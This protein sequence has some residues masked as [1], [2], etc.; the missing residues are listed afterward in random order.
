M[1]TLQRNLMATVLGLATLGL[2]AAA[3]AQADHDDVRFKLIL[4]TGDFGAWYGHGDGYWG[5]HYRRPKVVHNYYYRDDH[6]HGRHHH[7]P[8]KRVVEKYYYYFDGHPGKHKGHK[9]YKQDHGHHKGH[10]SRFDYRGDRAR[11]DH[12]DGGR[13]HRDVRY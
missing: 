3:P 9:K 6:Q 2:G 12:Q 13:R 1:K 8:R 10:G 7:K 11:Y 5:H 4:S